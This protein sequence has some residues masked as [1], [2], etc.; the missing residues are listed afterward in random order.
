MM[1]NLGVA[2]GKFLCVL[3]LLV[4]CTKKEPMYSKEDMLGL[5]PNEGADKVE[6]V[7]ARDINDAIPCSNYGE[8]CLSVHRL[9]ARGLDF[10]AVEFA[11]GKDARDCSRRVRGWVARNWLFDDVEKEP[12]L[13][14]LVEKY[15]HAERFTQVGTATDSAQKSPENG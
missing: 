3:I 9:K 12:E 1:I 8:G 4:A 14:R 7:L 6:I 5:T 11:T 2:V 15:F 10:I 13:E